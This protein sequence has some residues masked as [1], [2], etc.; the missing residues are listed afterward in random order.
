VSSEAGVE[1]TLAAYVTALLD[2]VDALDPAA[3]ARIRWLAGGSTARIRLDRETVLVRFVDELL[4]VRPDDPEA[5]V[6][7]T[8]STD[9]GTVLDLLAG[10][11]EVTQAMLAGRLEVVGA[12]DSVVAM[13]QIVEIVLDASARSA[14][15]QEVQ[16]DLVA[17]ASPRSGGGEARAG[18]PQRPSSADVAWYPDDIPPDELAL[19]VRLDLVRDDPHH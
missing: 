4:D 8:G 16:R 11:L 3:G 6:D 19:L 12:P 9:R 2:G 1:R 14:D 7:G 15:L 18:Q 10:R 17:A 13:L 5:A